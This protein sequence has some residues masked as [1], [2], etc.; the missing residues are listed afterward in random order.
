MDTNKIVELLKDYNCSVVS[1]DSKNEEV[2]IK[3]GKKA[4]KLEDIPDGSTFKIG[5]CEFI[6]L[7]KESCGIAALLK[8]FLYEG[9]F[10]NSNNYS[11]SEVREKINGEFYKKLEKEVGENNIIGHHVSLTALDGLND[12]ESGIT[13]KVSLLDVDRYRKYRKHIP[14]YGDWWWLATP[15][16]CKSNGYSSVVCCVDDGGALSGDVCDFSDGVRPFCIFNS[17]IFV[18]NN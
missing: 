2:V 4:V 13:D 5:K 18:S 17:S 10:G 14:N 7:G 15:W 6:K 1:E 16:S 3:V 12:Y 11:E 8:D 9:K